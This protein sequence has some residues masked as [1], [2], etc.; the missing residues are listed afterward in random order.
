MIMSRAAVV[1]FAALLVALFGAACSGGTDDAVTSA[2]EPERE[3]PAEE[4]AAEAQ[5]EEA[6]AGGAGSV[7]RVADTGEG[8]Q[9]INH[10]LFGLIIEGAYGLEMELV[11]VAPQDLEGVLT[12]GDVDLHLEARTPETAE[13]FDAA[14]AEGVL[15]NLGTI[16][17]AEDGF[18]VQ[19]GATPSFVAAHPDVVAFL[20]KMD[21]R[22]GSLG[23]TETWA[24]RRDGLTNQ[25]VAAYY[26]YTFDFEDR[27]KSWMPFENY[28]QAKLH[29]ETLYP[30][31]RRCTNCPEADPDA[32]GTR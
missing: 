18:E 13:W 23:K 10:E 15:I 29:M 16:Y 4:P 8:Y 27:M 24:K 7:V 19:K 28:R 21:T 26:M 17:E 30:D 5:P 20:E 3:S 22:A 9:W 12:S 14:V 6:E 32:P 11:P 25:E 1:L 2:P 31:F